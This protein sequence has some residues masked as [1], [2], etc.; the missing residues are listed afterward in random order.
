MNITRRALLW[1]AAAQ[2]MQARPKARLASIELVPVQATQRTIWLLVKLRTGDGRSGWGEAS[3][4]FGFF[5]PTKADA[6]RM[7]DELRALFAV[8]QGRS[9]LD[10]A[11]LREKAWKRASGGLVHATAF[12]AIE[13]AMCDLAGQLLDVPVYDL[14][15]GS[16]RERLPVYANINRAT[17]PRT[18]AGF[19]QTAV[20]AVADGFSAVKLA[21]WDGWPAT[22]AEQGIDAIRAVREAVG[23]KVRV[24]VD[25]HSFFDV[26]LAVDV[27]KRL[28]PYDL[29]WYEEPV[30]PTEVKKTLAIRQGIRQPMA[31][32][33]TLFGVAGFAPLCQAKA[34][35]VIMP[36]VKHCGGLLELTHIAAMAEAE[37]VAVAPHNPSGPISTAASVQVCAGMSNFRVLELQ[38]GESDWRKD[39][40]SPLEVFTGGEIAVPKSPGLGVTVNEKLAAQH[41]F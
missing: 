25:C 13:Q 29:T 7:E 32:G 6:A 41:R 9:P 23:G 4:A 5:A 16:T 38:W 2:T 11:W 10:V 3:D 37:A 20:R 35:E 26:K 31:G 17:K 21:P 12:S 36:D 39:L 8:V 33:E 19:A 27:A 18:P 34:V 22:T 24:M 1:G 14:L 30:A 40:V 15:G 28:E